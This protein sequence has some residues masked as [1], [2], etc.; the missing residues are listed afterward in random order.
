MKKLLPVL[1]MIG[2]AFNGFAQS[3]LFT[4]KEIT[5]ITPKQTQNK[6]FFK[7]LNSAPISQQTGERWF[8]PNRKYVGITVSKDT[9]LVNLPLHSDTPTNIFYSKFE[10]DYGGKISGWIKEGKCEAVSKK[11][12]DTCIKLNTKYLE[13][14]DSNLKQQTFKT[15][16]VKCKKIF[17]NNLPTKSVEGE[18]F[19][20][21]HETDDPNVDST[22]FIILRNRQKV[23]FFSTNFEIGIPVIPIKV[24][25][26]KI[27]KTIK[28]G[29]G[30]EINNKVDPFEFAYN[31]NIYLGARLG[32]TTYLYNKHSGM[33]S[34]NYSGYI[35]AFAGFGAFALKANNIPEADTVTLKRFDKD[36]STVVFNTG[37][38]MG[39]DFRGFQVG[40]YFGWDVPFNNDY[41]DL[42][43]FRKE[44]SFFIGFGVGYAIGV[45]KGKS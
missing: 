19:I 20:N 25:P 36:Q 27:E 12:C 5:Y 11:K 31:G 42:W 6:F 17:Q 13:L 4:F 15:I 43:Y 14:V 34:Y 33:K 26:Y 45:L 41:R 39:F 1:M 29:S 8:S 38:T 28:N 44:K 16:A 32:R 10:K 22:Y 21:Y 2:F 30:Q 3:G 37:I 18:Q 23:S 35:G 7:K 24:R 40:T 9:L